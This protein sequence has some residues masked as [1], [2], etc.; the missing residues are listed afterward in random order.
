MSAQFP[1][2]SRTIRR[3]PECDPSRVSRILQ[4]AHAN[5]FQSI[6][7]IVIGTWWLQ[8]DPV[9]RMTS[10]TFIR[11]L[12]HWIH[13]AL[14]YSN[15]GIDTLMGVVAQVRGNA[16]IINS[17]APSGSSGLSWKS[18]AFAR[19]Y[20]SVVVRGFSTNRRQGGKGRVSSP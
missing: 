16:E 6:D 13:P 3:A 9:R 2:L 14:T 18:M 8:K 15:V 4:Y 17:H 7:C 11:S 5:S 20:S 10:E 1:R 12:N 19:L